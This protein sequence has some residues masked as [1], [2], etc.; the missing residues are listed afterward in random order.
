MVDNLGMRSTQEHNGR[1]SDE[2][3]SAIITNSTTENIIVYGPKRAT[4]SGNYDKSWYI[5]H[6]GET[7]PDKWEF[8]GI[9]VPKDRKFEQENN[10]S[11]QGPVAVRYPVSKSVTITQNGDQYLENGEHNVGVFRQTEINWPVPEFNSEN[12][13]KMSSHMYQIQD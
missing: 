8:E 11:I 7:T 10:Y 1:M 9:F 12:C 13:K 2:G 4:D 3:L 6:P 5:L